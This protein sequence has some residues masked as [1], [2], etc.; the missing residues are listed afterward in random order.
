M[1][2]ESSQLIS[3]SAPG[4]QEEAKYWITQ[5][6]CDALGLTLLLYSTGTFLGVCLGLV[7]AP[8]SCNTPV[9]TA[10]YWTC[11]GTL[12]V[13][14]FRIFAS[15]TLL[16]FD[17]S[18]AF[19]FSSNIQSYICDHPCFVMNAKV[20]EPWSLQA[21][22]APPPHLSVPTF[23]QRSVRFD[24]MTLTLARQREC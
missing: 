17:S 9:S 16:A 7:A 10:R 21:F 13:Q 24:I 19:I 14:C 15:I 23:Q 12:L 6:R 22:S 3:R 11:E 2:W 4:R 8:N 20:K 5:S 18:N 1:L